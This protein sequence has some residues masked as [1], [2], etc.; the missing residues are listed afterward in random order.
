MSSN[1]SIT[2][3]LFLHEQGN[4]SVIG[5]PKRFDIMEQIESCRSIRLATAYARMSGWKRL[6]QAVTKC[7]ATAL[8]LTGSDNQF[9]QPEVLTR[10]MKLAE[11]D[12]VEARIA[13]RGFNFHPKV[14][15]V[16]GTDNSAPTGVERFAIVGSGNLSQGGL[17]SNVEC[18]LY[19]DDPQELD[20]LV[21]WFEGQFDLADA[22]TEEL[23]QRYKPL[24]L[25]ARRNIKQLREDWKKAQ[26][27]LATNQRVSDGRQ[28][29]DARESGTEY[30]VVNTDVRH[31][32]DN[33]HHMMNNH[34]ACA[35]EDP[36][37][38]GIEKIKKDDIVFLYQSFGPGLIAFG[39]ATGEIEKRD[40]NQSYCMRL[41]EFRRITPPI[42][43]SEIKR[44]DHSEI[45]FRNTVEHP[46]QELGLG[47]YK[48][49]LGRS[50]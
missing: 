23:I 45:V 50:S 5:L 22:V 31:G 33:H 35:F 27:V 11:Q 6:E 34:E 18:A 26:R 49:A 8:L 21:A 37:K 15:I 47:L 12:R 17:L 39:K 32:W 7:K 24:Y 30:F 10:W 1:S 43:A 44:L 38:Y 25:K 46:R 40:Y 28:L 20:Q 19:T 2:R 36:W 48:A 14:L 29:D 41:R 42:S 9:T 4:A 3:T 13:H 16:N